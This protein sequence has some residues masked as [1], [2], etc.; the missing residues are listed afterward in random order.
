MSRIFVCGDTHGNYDVSKLI[1]FE[2]KARVAGWNLTKDDY[3]IVC[4]DF[5]LIW[6][7]KQTGI[8]IES[9]P[10]DTCWKTD[11][12]ALCEFYEKLPWTTLFVDGNHE[13]FDRLETYKVE[14]WHGGRVQK[15]T[16]SIIHLLR[17]EIYEIDGKTIFAFG[18]AMSTDRGP[19]YGDTEYVIHKYWWPQEICS[20]T[21]KD[22]AFL[23]L[24]YWGD[25]VDYIITHDCPMGIN[26]FKAYRIS[27]VS[28]YLEQIRQTVKFSHW[29][30][31]HMHFDGDFGK[32]SVLY[33]KVVPLGGYAEE[34][35]EWH[36]L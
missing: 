34:V 11:E 20:D 17:G 7:Y 26:N 15:I 3:V 22:N 19:A 18:G 31:G 13:N 32:I 12:L 4:G 8:T 24:R 36:K 14:E 28:N 16:D 6:N 10:H 9:N 30:C 29:Y 33:N 35:Y 21:E 23:N 2:R 1:Q 25:E 5:G 27:S